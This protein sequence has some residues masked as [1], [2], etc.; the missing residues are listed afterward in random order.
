MLR[1]FGLEYRRVLSRKQIV[2]ILALI[3]LGGCIINYLINK[4]VKT[5]YGA[6]IPRKFIKK[7]SDELSSANGSLDETLLAKNVEDL[8][9]KLYDPGVAQ[10]NYVNGKW[11]LPSITGSPVSDLN[12]MSY[13]LARMK[14]VEE[15]EEYLNSVQETSEAL[16]DVLYRSGESGYAVKNILNI[17]NRYL[18]LHGTDPHYTDTSTL[19]FAFSGY[20][21]TVCVLLG[22]LL[23]AMELFAFDQVNG[24]VGIV[25][26][27]KEGRTRL[28]SAKMMVFAALTLLYELVSF[29][30]S[31]LVGC[32]LYGGIDM[33]APV[34]CVSGFLASPWKINQGTYMLLY[35]LVKYIGLMAVGTVIA[36]ILIGVTTF[37]EQM[38]MIVCVSVTELVLFFNIRYTSPLFILRAADPVSLLETESFFN[39][40]L[41]VDLFGTPVDSLQWSVCVSVLL[42]VVCCAVGRRIWNSSVLSEGLNTNEKEKGREGAVPAGVARYEFRKTF[43]NSRG[44]A[45]LLILL[46]V[47]ALVFS[48]Y[49]IYISFKDVWYQIYSFR[50]SGECSDTKKVY[51]GTRK[52]EI[53]TTAERIREIMSMASN[54]EIERSEAYRLCKEIEVG[55]DEE[56]GFKK[57]YSQYSYVERM[58]TEGKRAL[59]VDSLVYDNLLGWKYTLRDMSLLCISVALFLPQSVLL[60]HESG[61]E[62][63][64]SVSLH[65]RRRSRN[66]RIISVSCVLLALFLISFVPHIVKVGAELTFTGLG[67][68][69][70]SFESFSWCPDFVPIYAMLI[71]IYSFRFLL[72]YSEYGLLS[73]LSKR[74]K[75]KHVLYVIAF[76][77]GLLF[78]VCYY[79]MMS[80]Q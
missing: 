71:L 72:V 53:E 15:H 6:V 69:A 26:A 50:I 43:F 80:M 20:S 16:L 36:V 18:R 79:F 13:L 73:L 41:N 22:E 9:N 61:M 64:I 4:N 38:F 21:V 60:E 19:E 31:T 77:I 49:S 66:F 58:N 35:L 37:F 10:E 17:E 78:C 46:I 67:M 24:T 12:T 1:L 44:L 48:S 55:T 11:L 54:G 40:C 27:T 2:C 14:E 3:L 51:M 34:Q 42:S 70:C 68:P 28:F 32:L 39:D 29:G 62:Q 33:S 76:S 30:C 56:A 23:L 8:S 75:S 63:L 74:I 57:A 52:E 45:L 7:V 25:K 5:D 47:Q 65:G 59:Y